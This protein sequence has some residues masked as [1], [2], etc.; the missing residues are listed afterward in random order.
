MSRIR[1]D[2]T[3]FTPSQPAP[4]KITAIHSVLVFMKSVEVRL[5][6]QLHTYSPSALLW[7]NKW[8]GELCGIKQMTCFLLQRWM[9]SV[10]IPRSL[11]NE[12]LT[13]FCCPGSPASRPTKTGVVSGRGRRTDVCCGRLWTGCAPML[14]W[15]PRLIRTQTFGYFQPHRLQREEHA[16]HCLRPWPYYIAYN[17]HI[18]I[19][20]SVSWQFLPLTCY[21]LLSVCFN[22][23]FRS[24]PICGAIYCRV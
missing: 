21:Y 18:T 3:S 6:R 15:A 11:H 23:I 24:V 17:A 9:Q 10:L 5:S 1:A 22:D 13:V 7:S 2:S 19:N 14:V 4:F 20:K 16:E 12:L 8:M